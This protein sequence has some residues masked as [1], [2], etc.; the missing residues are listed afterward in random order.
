MPPHKPSKSDLSRRDTSNTTKGDE[1]MEQAPHSTLSDTTAIAQD[2]EEQDLGCSSHASTP[3]TWTKV[4]HKG[5]A[6]KP[7]IT[8]TTCKDDEPSLHS[9]PSLF[10]PIQMSQS[11]DSAHVLV[12]DTSLPEE[13]EWEEEEEVE[14][15]EVEE[16]EVEEEEV[17]EEGG[18]WEEVANEEQHQRH[19]QEDEMARLTQDLEDFN[20]DMRNEFELR[21]GTQWKPLQPWP[22]TEWD[23]YAGWDLE[24]DDKLDHEPDL[25][26]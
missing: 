24:S 15:E 18:W 10:K 4:L 19:Q 23:L 14:E 2:T 26:D 21:T 13:G 25:L 1:E 3:T 5:E 20:R 16:E 11:S 6:D 12:E 7:S 17:E 8:L 22:N 9:E